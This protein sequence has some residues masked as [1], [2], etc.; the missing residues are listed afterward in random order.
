MSKAR[1]VPRTTL[2]SLLVNTEGSDL[3]GL[4]QILILVR[5]A[6]VLHERLHHALEVVELAL[7]LL[8]VVAH[9]V[10]RV[11]ELLL[12]HLHHLNLVLEAGNRGKCKL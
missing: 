12:A 6:A 7:H 1:S 10:H 2:H 3:V 5:D 11:L 8:V 4:L 9:L